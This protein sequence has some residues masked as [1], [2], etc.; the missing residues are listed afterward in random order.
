[1]HHN[2]SSHA[3]E[4]LDKTYFSHQ[5]SSRYFQIKKNKLC[6]SA[7]HPDT[8][9]SARELL[10]TRSIHRKLCLLSLF[11]VP[12][13]SRN[14]WQCRC[15][16]VCEIKRWKTDVFDLINDLNL[17]EWKCLLFLF[18]RKLI[19]LIYSSL[20][21]FFSFSFVNTGKNTAHSSSVL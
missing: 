2:K 21:F 18:I 8:S 5:C 19:Q 3:P 1:M 6:I 17:Q 12:Q 13:A 14:G 4:T 11:D 9:C 7:S 16:L 15:E 20:G 10:I